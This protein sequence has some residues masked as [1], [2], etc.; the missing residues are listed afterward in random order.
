MAGSYVK[1]QARAVAG[2]SCGCLLAAASSGAMR[3]DVRTDVVSCV[4]LLNQLAMAPARVG[5]AGGSFIC[6]GSARC[7]SAPDLFH[8]FPLDSHLRRAR[9]S[10][11][12]RG[13]GLTWAAGAGLGQRAGSRRGCGAAGGPVVARAPKANSYHLEVEEDV[14]LGQ[15]LTPA[16]LVGGR[17]QVGRGVVSG[18]AW[19]AEHVG[20]V[21]HAEP[22]VHLA[23]ALHV[24]RLE[25][26]GGEEGVPVCVLMADDLL[27]VGS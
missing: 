1:A 10:P 7:A 2:S 9:Y 14:R 20:L 18:V 13:R 6:L 26:A 17:P 19:L 27:A 12:F 8:S 25:V 5:A 3:R 4:D 23:D 11:P 21:D 22:V 15:E 16:R 24:L